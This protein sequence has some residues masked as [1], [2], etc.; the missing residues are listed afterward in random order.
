MYCSECDFSYCFKCKLSNFL[1]KERSLAEQTSRIILNPVYLQQ[2]KN[3]LALKSFAHLE[4]PSLKS[5]DHLS[6]TELS[7]KSIS[8]NAISKEEEVYW[9]SRADL[10]NTKSQS[11]SGHVCLVCGRY[12]GNLTVLRIK[13][14]T[15]LKLLKEIAICQTCALN[16]PESQS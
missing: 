2:L 4:I 11:S 8:E 1:V 13:D 3:K 7:I 6:Y 10:E 12:K 15:L 9:R 14:P 16:V 5:L